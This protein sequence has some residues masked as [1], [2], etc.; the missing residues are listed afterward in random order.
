[1]RDGTGAQSS[2]ADSSS[3]S[4]SSPSAG[5]GSKTGGPGSRNH[6]TNSHDDDHSNSGLPTGFGGTDN[7]D[8]TSTPGRGE[9][10]SSQNHGGGNWGSDPRFNGGHSSN[11]GDSLFNNLAETT[12]LTDPFASGLNGN[13]FGHLD[14]EN[15]EIPFNDNLF[16]DTAGL[17]RYHT[18][19]PDVI[20]EIQRLEN[21]E[22]AESM[23]NSFLGS[24]GTIGGTAYDALHDFF[25][26]PTPAELAARDYY[27]QNVHN[28]PAYDTYALGGQVLGVGAMLSPANPLVQTAAP[29]YSMVPNTVANFANQQYRTSIAEGLYDHSANETPRNRYEAEQRHSTGGR[30]MYAP[31]AVF[32][33]GSPTG[34]GSQIAET[35]PMNLIKPRSMGAAN[36]LEGTDEQSPI[37]E[38]IPASTFAPVE[39]ADY[40]SIASYTPVQQE[41]FTSGNNQ[42][43]NNNLLSPGE[44]ST[45]A[46]LFNPGKRTEDLYKSLNQ[47]SM[48]WK[49][50]YV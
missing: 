9:T 44:F 47:N 20:S 12:D 16:R 46:N 36:F 39:S 34:R 48:L 27:N 14:V 38:Q 3:H 19:N 8:G 23:L 13:A 10:Q 40:G 30:E 17:D 49:G 41:E 35:R 42:L 25:S 2:G 28:A 26:P 11:S 31:R 22:N 15:P 18:Q 4:S 50:G 6:H 37:A 1:M 24:I 29:F 21:A 45:A 33:G 5:G 32:A 7:L 43:L